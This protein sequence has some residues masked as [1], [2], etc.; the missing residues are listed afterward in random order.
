MKHETEVHF[1]FGTVILGFLSIFKKCKASS[2]F[3]A[4]NSVFLSRGQSDMIPLSR[5]GGDLR[6]SLGSPQGIQTSHHLVT[7]N[8]SLNL[9]HCREICPSFESSLSRYIP[10]E[11]EIT[12]SLSPTYCWGK[13]PHEVL[14]ESWLK[15]SIK[16]RE[17]A[18]NLGWYVVHG[19]FLEL[20]YWY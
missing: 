8:T 19:A 3:E 14:V 5:W 18:V 20:L 2:P 10:L 9:S 11:T 1:L 6:V 4:L 17:S 16:D 15:S 12:E 7:W 13:T